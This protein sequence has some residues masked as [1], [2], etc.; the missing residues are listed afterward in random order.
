[1]LQRGVRMSA[2]RSGGATTAVSSTWC[3]R[4]PGKFGDVRRLSNSI[5]GC[6]RQRQGALW[7]SGEL[8]KCKHGWRKDANRRRI[9]LR[10]S[11]APRP[12]SVPPPDVGGMGTV[13]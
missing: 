8:W 10:L 1:M 13:G 12:N 6:S 4:S 7:P 11:R 9:P 5:F 3:N 2:E